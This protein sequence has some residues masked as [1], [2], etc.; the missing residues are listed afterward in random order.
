MDISE[1]NLEMKAIIDQCIGYDP[2]N[3][4]FIAVET[5]SYSGKNTTIGSFQRNTVED[6]IQKANAMLNN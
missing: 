6:L 5:N 3:D 1:E 4:R 2:D